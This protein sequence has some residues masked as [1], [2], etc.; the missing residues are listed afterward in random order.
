MIRKITVQIGM[1]I[2]LSAITMMMLTH[3][4]AALVPSNIAVNSHVQNSGITFD[5]CPSS[6]PSQ[7]VIVTAGDNVR[8]CV[9]LTLSVNFT[10]AIITYGFW[11]ITFY[12]INTNN[13]A[14]YSPSGT[15]QV[16]GTPGI[17]HDMET[18]QYNSITKGDTITIDVA[19]NVHCYGGSPLVELANGSTFTTFTIN[20]I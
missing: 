16:S 9:D 13:N 3:V 1:V 14:I 17:D 19:I 6:P 11:N 12:Q 10:G 4:N 7:S 2:I 20:C 8:V 18:Y 15:L 5:T